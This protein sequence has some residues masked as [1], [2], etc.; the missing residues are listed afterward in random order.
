MKQVILSIL[1][2]ALFSIFLSCGKTYTTPIRGGS[3]YTEKPLKTGY[4]KD[5]GEGFE[6]RGDYFSRM[7]GL[8]PQKGESFQD[9][10]DR[11]INTLVVQEYDLDSYQTL[12]K[13]EEESI[14]NLTS[15]LEQLEEQ[16]L[17]LRIQY[18]AMKNESAEKK[19]ER[20]AFHP[21]KVQKGDTLQKISQQVFG[22]H[23]AWLALYQFN[24]FYVKNPNLIEVG[25]LIWLP[26]F[27]NF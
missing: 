22:T 23:T 12:I 5:Q 24:Q 2:C 8:Q 14:V 20:L 6:Q 16:G 18:Q 7:K 26:A 1:A 9:F 4:L 25:E 3:L 11:L 15:Q 27:T 19:F 21:Y 13:E 10:E 17:D